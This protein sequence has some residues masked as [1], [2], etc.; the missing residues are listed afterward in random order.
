M[1]DRIGNLEEFTRYATDM[2]ALIDEDQKRT[3]AAVERMI[4]AVR[5]MNE[6]VRRMDE[7][8]QRTDEA[9]RGTDEA[10]RQL[11]DSSARRDETLQR[12]MQAMA[13]IQADIVRIDQ[14][15][16]GS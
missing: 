10:V 11:Q 12:M 6:A 16:D 9:V 7:A 5:R 3:R 4:E 15:H 8:V 2:I 14:T 1:E 13:V